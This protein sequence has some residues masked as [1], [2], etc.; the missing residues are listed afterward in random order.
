VRA[1]EEGK[2]EVQL[3]HSSRMPV[4]SLLVVF[5]HRGPNGYRATNVTFRDSVYH[6]GEETIGI[7]DAHVFPC[8]GDAGIECEFIGYA[9]LYPDGTSD[10]DPSLVAHLQGRRRG[11]LAG[12]TALLSQLSAALPDG[13]K[14]KLKA[15]LTAAIDRATKNAPPRDANGLPGDEWF[16][17]RDAYQLALDALEN[18]DGRTLAQVAP[19]IRGA[20][21]HKVAML[22][23]VLH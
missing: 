16:G 9:V 13:S 2:I 17:L 14:A 7:H 21:E 8:G 1:K 22:K 5:R 10:G 4:S 18:A 12:L 19:E 6:E 15:D 20:A 3:E 11:Y 23:K